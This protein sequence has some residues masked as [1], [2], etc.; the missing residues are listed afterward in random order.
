MGK[1]LDINCEHCGSS[2]VYKHG[3][4]KGNQ[5]YIC[6]DCG[7][8]FPNSPPG[9]YKEKSLLTHEQICH[10]RYV[11]GKTLQAIGDLADLSRERVRQILEENPKTA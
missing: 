1:K 2:N 4:Y 11:D 7:K 5:K 10:L 3:K 8:T 9:N 6:R